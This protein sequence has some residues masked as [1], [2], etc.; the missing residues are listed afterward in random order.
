MK[1]I[2]TNYKAQKPLDQ[3]FFNGKGSMD[4]KW[5]GQ[6][7][8][9][10]AEN[11]SSLPFSLQQSFTHYC[12]TIQQEK[13]K[14]ISLQSPR[15]SQIGNKLAKASAYMPEKLFSKEIRGVSEIKKHLIRLSQSTV[16]VEEKLN[17][18]KVFSALLSQPHTALDQF[19]KTEDTK[20]NLTLIVDDYVSYHSRTNQWFHNSIIET[21]KTIKGINVYHNGGFRG[22]FK[23]KKGNYSSEMSD[24]FTEFIATLPKKEQEKIIVF[25]QGCGDRDFY[26]YD[27]I[28]SIKANITFCT[29]FAKGCNC[30]CNQIRVA[31]KSD[32]KVIYEMETPEDLAKL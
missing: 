11:F 19:K 22:S 12:S 1:T 20:T 16:I 7:Y 28:K 24:Y 23:D 29:C 13:T 2:Y 15:Q 4:Y 21:A 27:Q 6:T 17:Y 3:F 26:V 9:V 10:N 18:P 25:T 8:N 14:K 32:I 31:E 5:R 30:G